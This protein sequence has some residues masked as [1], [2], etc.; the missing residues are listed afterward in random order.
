[1]RLCENKIDFFKI[2]F[3]FYFFSLLFTNPVSAQKRDVLERV[4]SEKSIVSLKKE[5]ENIDKDSLSLRT[6]YQKMIVEKALE[7]KNYEELLLSYLK[8]IAL[9]RIK[10]NYEEGESYAELAISFFNRSDNDS[11]KMKIWRTKGAVLFEQAKY[12][13]A[14]LSFVN[15]KEIAQ[16]INDDYYSLIVDMNIGLVKLQ[17]NESG[18]EEGLNMFLKILSVLDEIGESNFSAENKDFYIKTLVAISKVYLELK[19]YD[20]AMHYHKL[21]LEKSIEFKNTK[22]EI[23]L[24]GGIG[25]IYGEKGEYEKA[26]ETLD[27]AIKR[28]DES[29]KYKEVFSFIYLLKGTNFFKM[30]MYEKAID[31]LLQS[32]ENINATGIDNLDLQERY[33][34]LARSYQALGDYEKSYEYF[35]KYEDLDKVNDQKRLNLINHVSE[36]YDLEGLKKELKTLESEKIKKE[37]NYKW[38]IGVLTLLLLTTLMIVMIFRK[39]QRIYKQQFEALLTKSNKK[40]VAFKTDL[41]SDEKAK[42]ILDKLIKFEEQKNYLNQNCTLNEVAKKLKTNTSYLSMVINKYKGKSFSVYLSE[43]RINN[44]VDRLTNDKKFRSYSIKSIAEETGFNRAESFSKAFKNNTGIYPSYFIKN[45]D[46]Q[47]VRSL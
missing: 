31:N 32:E 25:R 1:M 4:L 47:N 12:E 44:A 16:K 38:I 42:E 13:K 8:L 28:L 9:E 36:K 3:I 5:V 2:F 24:L 21:G 18:L 45:I 11:L 26:I 30:K 46:K 20:A 37:Y 27:K 19:N 39:N 43:L 35:S 22:V 33:P 6:L 17:I 23:L 40:E 14:L 7:E 10:G 15:A 29:E 41:V 34:L